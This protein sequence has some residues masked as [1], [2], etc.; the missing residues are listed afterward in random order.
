MGG[1]TGLFGF[2]EVTVLG[3]DH[4]VRARAVMCDLAWSAELATGHGLHRDA[5]WKGACCR[6][7]YL[8][9]RAAV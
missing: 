3:L 2:L 1:V 7:R 4:V 8:W 5:S 9:V 6:V